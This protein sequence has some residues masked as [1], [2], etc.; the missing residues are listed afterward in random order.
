VDVR[1]RL[2]RGLEMTV[3]ILNIGTE[4]LLGDVRDSHAQWIGKRL[5]SRGARV[6]RQTVVADGAPIRQALIECFGRADVVFVTGGLGPTTDDITREVVAELLGRRLVESPEI[7]HAI[8][9]RFAARG[10]QTV[11]RVYRQAMVPEGGVVLANAH[12]TAPGLYFEAVEA[13]SWG[14]PHLFLL[15]GPPRE[16]R[17]MFEVHVEPVLDRLFDGLPL[18]E[19]R[20]F[21]FAGLGESMLEE[22]IGLSLDAIPGL[23]VGY[24]ARPGEVDLRLIGSRE[25]IDSIEPRI[26][27]A[28]GEHLLPA[29]APSL[30]ESVV[31]ALAARKMTLATAESCTGGLLSSRITDVPGASEVF[32]RGFVTYSDAAK[33]DML[34]VPLELL[35]AHGA[36]SAPVASAMAAGARKVSA[37]DHALAL[38]GFAGP[39]GDD[40]GLLFIAHAGPDGEVRCHESRLPA[41]RGIFKHLAV[42]AALDILRRALSFEP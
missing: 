30:E 25:L 13:V 28:V 31:R 42:R 29:D 8:D 10:F 7:R 21:R 34:G 3:E 16:L 33:H 1:D 17:P 40:P 37:S 23:E 6:S 39:G 15:P 41:E 35:R 38:T 36:V 14:P 5:L 19:C 26:R 11:E 24:C 12:G 4:L 20:I 18:P 22:R 27:E 32:H 2:R 9:E